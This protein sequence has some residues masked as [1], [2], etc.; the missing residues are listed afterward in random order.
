VDQYHEPLSDTFDDPRTCPENLLL[1]FHRLPWDHRLRSGPTLWEGLV[2]HYSRGAEGARAMEAAWAALEG[3]VDD[4]RFQ[5]VRQKLQRQAAEAAEWRDKCLR[6]FQQ[7]SGRPLAGPGA[8][9]G[10]AASATR[11]EDL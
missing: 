11:N 2:R 7:F 4:E 6:Y 9:R 3:R 10:A 1:W 5:A 8:S